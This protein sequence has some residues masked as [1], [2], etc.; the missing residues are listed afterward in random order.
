MLDDY[1]SRY[2]Q[3]RFGLKARSSEEGE[4]LFKIVCIKT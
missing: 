3:M 2:N 4:T 1:S